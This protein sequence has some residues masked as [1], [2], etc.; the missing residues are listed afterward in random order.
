MENQP[1]YSPVQSTPPIVTNQINPG[2][3]N[4]N[5]NQNNYMLHSILDSLSG[6][7]KFI[8]IYTIVIGAITC[9]G[10]ISA[11][12]GVPMIFSGIALNN[13]SKTLKNYKEFNNQ[14]T[15]NDFFGFLNK[16]FK[17]Q[18]IFVIIGIA[19]SV[20]YIAFILIFVI[21]SVYTYS[22]Y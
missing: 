8:G 22:S 12:I 16:Y 7:M 14:F 21:L 9:I 13:A 1:D 19:L 4:F 2:N 17:I 6:W 20:L 18:G 3:G 10:I 15:L 11:A 5:Y